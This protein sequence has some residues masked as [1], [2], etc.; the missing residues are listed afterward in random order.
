MKVTGVGYGDGEGEVLRCG[1]SNVMVIFWGV[2]L[3]IYGLGVRRRRWL[4]SWV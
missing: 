3:G 4:G 2:G 1:E